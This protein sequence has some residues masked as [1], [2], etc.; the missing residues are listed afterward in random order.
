MPHH[1]HHHQQ[2]Q[3]HNNNNNN[4]Q[5]KKQKRPQKINNRHALPLLVHTQTRTRARIHTHVVLKCGY[6]P[7]SLPNVAQS[8]TVWSS[9]RLFWTGVLDR[10]RD[11]KKEHTCRRAQ[12]DTRPAG[13]ERPKAKAGGVSNQRKLGREANQSEAKR[14]EALPSRES[15]KV[16]AGSRCVPCLKKQAKSARPTA[17]NRKTTS[18]QEDR[19]RIENNAMYK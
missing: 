16:D 13:S 8:T 17:Q 5:N 7:K 18:G 1:H 4:Q 2:Q 9:F 11:Q 10:P 6:G 15:V 3:Q 19:N 14:S 12:T